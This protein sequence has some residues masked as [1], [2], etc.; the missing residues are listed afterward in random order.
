[1]FA[2]SM[3]LRYRSNLQSEIPLKK[4]SSTKELCTISRPETVEINVPGKI[5]LSLTKARNNVVFGLPARINNI[6]ATIAGIVNNSEGTV[7][8]PASTTNL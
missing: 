5:N 6:M 7:T 4:P 2:Q 1:M 8:I 3:H